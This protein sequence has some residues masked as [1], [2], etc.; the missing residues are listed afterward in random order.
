MELVRDICSLGRNAR[1]DAAIKVRQPLN[2]MI[3]PLVD[4]AVI[5]DFE[6]IIK[7]ELN[8]KEIVYKDD[9]TEYMDYIVKAKL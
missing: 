4:E 3:L 7:E 5:D 6:S 9:M 1:E 2:F 8:I